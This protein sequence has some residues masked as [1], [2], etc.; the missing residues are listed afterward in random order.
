[1]DMKGPLPLLRYRPPFPDRRKGPSWNDTAKEKVGTP[2]S[3]IVILER[4]GL[5]PPKVEGVSKVNSRP[6]LREYTDS[7]RGF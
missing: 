3:S 6:T 1:M 7:I 4:E 2:P 5:A